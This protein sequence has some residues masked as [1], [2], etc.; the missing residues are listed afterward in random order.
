MGRRISD[1]EPGNVRKTKSPPRRES[2]RSRHNHAPRERE[3]ER[4]SKN[5]EKMEARQP[6]QPSIT[7]RQQ[8]G[9]G[10]GGVEGLKADEEKGKIMMGKPR[11]ETSTRTHA[12]H[13][14]Q[15]PG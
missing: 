2:A 13:A 11:Y 1:E 6:Q 4:A 12:S 15:R 8:V 7:E 5:K 9:G 14:D 10:E 3:S